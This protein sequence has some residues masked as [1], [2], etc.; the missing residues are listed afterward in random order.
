MALQTLPQSDHL[1]ALELLAGMV[2]PEA[3]VTNRNN[4]LRSVFCNGERNRTYILTEEFIVISLPLKSV[5]EQAIYL[6]RRTLLSESHVRRNLWNSSI[7]CKQRNPIV[8]SLRWK[9]TL[10]LCCDQKN[11]LEY[12]LT[13][14]SI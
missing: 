4:L 8:F 13:Q 11:L 3:C 6:I 9:S 1:I 14:K 5:L 10:E 2:S 12:V 7:H